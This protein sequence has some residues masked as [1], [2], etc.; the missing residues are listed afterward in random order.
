MLEGIQVIMIEAHGHK[1][2]FH[3]AIEDASGDIPPSA[4]TTAASPSSIMAASTRS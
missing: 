4:S 3:L 1:P 2:N